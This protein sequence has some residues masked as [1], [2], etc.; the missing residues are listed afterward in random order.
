MIYEKKRFFKY[1]IKHLT[2]LTSVSLKSF[3]QVFNQTQLVKHKVIMRLLTAYSIFYLHLISKLIYFFAECLDFFKL[4]VKFR[5][6][7]MLTNPH[8]CSFILTKFDVL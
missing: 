1:E 5:S 2:D 4:N 6:K 8:M 7:D 3:L